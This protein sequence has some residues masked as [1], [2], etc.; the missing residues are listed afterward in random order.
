MANFPGVGYVIPSFG[1]VMPLIE[2]KAYHEFE[3]MNEN[4]VCPNCGLRARRGRAEHSEE[5]INKL[6][7]IY[8]YPIKTR[9]LTGEETCAEIIIWDIIE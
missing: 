5:N 9:E 4:F 7:I 3:P 6:Y 2:V 1:G 8:P